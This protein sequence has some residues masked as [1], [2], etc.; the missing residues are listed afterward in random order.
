MQAIGEVFDSARRHAAVVEK[1]CRLLR[2]CLEDPSETSSLY[3][4]H[5]VLSCL[6]EVT[7]DTAELTEKAKALPQ[8]A[9]L[10]A[11]VSSFREAL[12]DNDRRLDA[13]EAYFEQYGYIPMPPPAG[14]V[15]VGKTTVAP[16]T[17]ALEPPAPTDAHAAAPSP[18]ETTVP[19]RL[20]REGT[21][22]ADDDAS[23][24]TN[25]G[26][27]RTQHA[28]PPGEEADGM[29]MTDAG[30]GNDGT[31]VW[32]LT[33]EDNALL[34]DMTGEGEA[35]SETAPAGSEPYPSLA[36]TQA[37]VDTVKAPPPPPS[38]AN[39]P[40][41]GL[42]GSD[43]EDTGEFEFMSLQELGISSATLS[44]LQQNEPMATVA[45]R[46]PGLTT[47]RLPAPVP[48]IARIA[49]TGA[50]ESSNNDSLDEL[51]DQTLHAITTVEVLP[52][53]PFVGNKT[54][55]IATPG[56]ISKVNPGQTHAEEE[57]G[58]VAV[59]PAVPAAV[60]ASLPSPA[61][62][63]EPAPELIPTAFDPVTEDEYEALPKFISVTLALED[64]NAA[65]ED[66]KGCILAT[67][68]P[69]SEVIFTQNQLFD[70]LGLGSKAKPVLLVLL[71]MQRLES[72][73][74]GADGEPLYS[75]SHV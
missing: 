40:L 22:T 53:T 30:D 75:F 69:P 64:L 14:D 7:A 48:A 32:A 44:L 51:A 67:E 5:N 39:G 58:A 70:D 59:A 49:A 46:T 29:V 62:E 34:E 8:S 56:T 33:H 47:R 25:E 52:A 38:S 2:E 55:Q 63:D 28:D 41:E 11:L 17:A 4:G 37:P 42:L 10:S 6:A 26:P 54:R 18:R 15:L 16:T 71:K 21:F 23:T 35:P 36:T 19:T 20:V 73:G 24:T 12:D 66:I 60:A 31:D 43:D 65:I 13:I 72:R 45:P 57:E 3:P 50:S 68:A 74:R 9:P 61:V 1:D 27:T